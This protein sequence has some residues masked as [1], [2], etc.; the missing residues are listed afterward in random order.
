MH[1]HIY[2]T[3]GFFY[4][5][6]ELQKYSLRVDACIVVTLSYFGTEVVY[7]PDLIESSAPVGGDDVVGSVLVHMVI[8]PDG[9]VDLISGQ[10]KVCRGVE[11]S[12]QKPT[13]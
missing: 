13:Q 12:W 6:Q 1:L 7:V 3:P 5:C 2:K 10:V 4:L 9:G 8:Q 11:G